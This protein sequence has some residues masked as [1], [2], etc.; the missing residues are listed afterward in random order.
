MGRVE[1]AT[2]KVAIARERSV[3]FTANF[4]SWWAQIGST[5]TL[6]GERIGGRAVELQ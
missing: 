4:V 1:G 6:N 5:G 3:R 2:T